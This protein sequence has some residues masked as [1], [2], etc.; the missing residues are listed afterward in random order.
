[1]KIHEITLDTKELNEA[2]EM[3]LKNKGLDVQVASIQKS[4]VK[5]A[6]WQIDAVAKED[7]N[8]ALVELPV[9]G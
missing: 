1:M 3:W 9:S 4:Y 7:F 8:K 6:D 5:G 2:V